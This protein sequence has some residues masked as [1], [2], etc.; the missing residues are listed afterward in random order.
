MVIQRVGQN[1][2]AS[3]LLNNRERC[4]VTD[5]KSVGL[6][7]DDRNGRLN[8]LTKMTGTAKTLQYHSTL[9]V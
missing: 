1:I 6:L 3:D 2:K 4:R 5:G 8:H 7:L 9:L